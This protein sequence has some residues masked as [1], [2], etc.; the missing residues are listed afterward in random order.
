MRRS[1][2]DTGRTSGGGWEAAASGGRGAADLEQLEAERLDALE[3]AEEGGL[4]GDLA[5]DHRVRG[6]RASR[7]RPSNAPISAALRRP[8][9]VIS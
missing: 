9:T 8:R 3:H 6:G 4:V 7:V 1:R 5:A 2:D